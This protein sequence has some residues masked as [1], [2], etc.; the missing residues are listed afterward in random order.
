MIQTDRQTDGRECN[1]SLQASQ[2]ECALAAGASRYARTTAC[3]FAVYILCSRKNCRISIKP[4]S[5]KVAQTL[6]TCDLHT[7]LS[8]LLKRPLSKTSALTGDKFQRQLS[9]FW[10]SCN[11]D[12]WSRRCQTRLKS[13]APFFLPGIYLVC[14]KNDLQKTD[15]YRK[16]YYAFMLVKCTCRMGR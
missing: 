12:T 5:T 3:I 4:P 6:T 7:S 11:Y 2:H 10:Q 1:G 13:S 9:I 8:E 14:A 16:K 15:K